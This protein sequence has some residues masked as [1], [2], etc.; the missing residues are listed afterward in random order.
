[1]QPPPAPPTAT[2][3]ERAARA[4]QELADARAKHNLEVAALRDKYDDALRDIADARVKETDLRTRVRDRDRT[5]QSLEKDLQAARTARDELTTRVA[6]LGEELHLARQ[7]LGRSTFKPQSDSGW[8]GRPQAATT[9]AAGA[10][11]RTEGS[12]PQPPAG[13]PQPGPRA[14]GEEATPPRP[15]D[16]TTPGAGARTEGAIPQS[17]AGRSGASPAPIPRRPTTVLRREAHARAQPVN[18][19]YNSEEDDHLLTPV[20]RERAQILRLRHK[21][22]ADLEQSG[23]PKSAWYR[24]WIS[25]KSIAE[26]LLDLFF[27]ESEEEDYA[28]D[29]RLRDPIELFAP[30]MT[31][32]AES[33]ETGRAARARKNDPVEPLPPSDSPEFGRWAGT[34][35]KSVVQAHNLRWFACVERDDDAIKFYKWLNSVYCK[36][37]RRRP[38]GIRYLQDAMSNDGRVLSGET[39][40]SRTESTPRESLGRY[41][42]A[43]ATHYTVWRFFRAAPVNTWPVGMRLASGALPVGDGFGVPHE[44]DVR[45]FFL[46]WHILPQRGAANPHKAHDASI[47][48]LAVELFSI[49]GWYESIVT[50]GGYATA[51][52]E[53]PA[54]Y[55]FASDDANHVLLAAWFCTHGLGM[56]GATIR[57]LERWG[58]FT[59]NHDLGRPSLDESA[60]PSEPS[61]IEAVAAPPHVARIVKFD[62][63]G[64]GERLA[65]DTESNHADWD[66]LINVE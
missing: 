62:E 42:V 65:E 20:E 45:A 16:R 57:A 25:Q 46:L 39:I 32:S 21:P 27:D 64:W 23:Q 47:H 35:I 66:E 10:S 22:D 17:S 19:G 31:R 2:G 33:K 61:T 38:V 49:A 1:M 36:P 28:V 13:R 54:R 3:W 26:D 29:V 41:P 4:Y 34:T 12:L 50:A 63:L 7:R 11:A 60:W 58:R 51:P 6:R 56:H 59:R 52:A 53:D 30:K 37:Q 5:I 55:P 15:A 24:H 44:D 18:A 40:I 48:Q 14:G 8:Q 43:S 9:M